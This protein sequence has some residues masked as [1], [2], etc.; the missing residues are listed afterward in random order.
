MARAGKGRSCLDFL[1]SSGH[2]PVVT[3]AFPLS[4]HLMGPWGFSVFRS[5]LFE[6]PVVAY[7][8][9]QKPPLGKASWQPS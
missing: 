6:T 5:P 3:S 4:A 7:S 2:Q 1:V 8:L 9:P